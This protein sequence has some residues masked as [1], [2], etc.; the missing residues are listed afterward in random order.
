MFFVYY[1][2]LCAH[3]TLRIL[4][5]DTTHR[6]EYVIAL[7]FVDHA[8]MSE[9]DSKACG[10][11]AAQF[12][13]QANSAP[14]DD[15]AFRRAVQTP[16]GVTLSDCDCQEGSQQAQMRRIS[17]RAVCELHERCVASLHWRQS[18]CIRNRLASAQI[19]PRTVASCTATT[20][21]LVAGSEIDLDA[22]RS[23]IR[24]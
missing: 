24:A 10:K 14:F 18:A 21:A 6:V 8:M 15:D 4:E 12:E 1:Y 16:I 20:R 19:S 22:V 7:T 23:S 13:A 9:W 11:I 2:Y 5:S 17:H 3:S